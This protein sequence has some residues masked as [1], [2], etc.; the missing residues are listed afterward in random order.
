L[1]DC[2]QVTWWCGVM[3]VV[4]GC[5]VSRS[6]R[7]S[8]NSKQSSIHPTPCSLPSLYSLEVHR[9]LRRHFLKIFHL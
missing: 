5:L 1:W 7:I 3:L 9:K 8:T 4:Q 6:K 2:P